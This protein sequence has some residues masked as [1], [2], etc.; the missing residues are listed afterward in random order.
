MT[1][2]GSFL[3]AL[4]VTSESS[5]ETVT[6]VCAPPSDGRY[7]TISPELGTPLERAY[8]VAGWAGA[9]VGWTGSVTTGTTTQLAMIPA[10]LSDGAVVSITGWAAADDVPSLKRMCVDEFCILGLVPPS[11]KGAGISDCR[12]HHAWRHLH[13]LA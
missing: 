6:D 5:A 2:T 9:G 8:F 4:I 1:D 12:L 7:A 10:R 13:L 11:F 3:L